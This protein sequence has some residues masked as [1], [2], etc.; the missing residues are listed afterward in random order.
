MDPATSSS[1]LIGLDGELILAGLAVASIIFTQIFTTRWNS[2][3]I[4]EL[5]AQVRKVNGRTYRH[6][7][8]IA[9]IQGTCAA[10]HGIE[11]E[12][13]DAPES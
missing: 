2:K 11:Y 1:S 4:Q 13:D 3:K 7:Q 8:Q 10:F 12:E 6:S 5:T 9:R